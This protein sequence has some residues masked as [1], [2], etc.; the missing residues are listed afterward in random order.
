[1]ANSADTSRLPS[2]PGICQVKE[3]EKASKI[4]NSDQNKAFNFV[5]TISPKGA[6]TTPEM[7]GFMF[8]A[9][10]TGCTF[11]STT[12]ESGMGLAAKTFNIPVPMR[13]LRQQHARILPLPRLGEKAQGGST[14]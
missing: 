5:E 1:M 14:H 10:V 11:A 13:R 12:C 4:P 7:L 2:A 8:W 9:A 6:G 3:T